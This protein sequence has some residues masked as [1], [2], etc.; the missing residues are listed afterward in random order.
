LTHL[1]IQP[2]NAT[3]GLN[4]SGKAFDDEPG[5]IGGY[6]QRRIH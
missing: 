3:R 4:P 2:A 5:G 6:I 1:E